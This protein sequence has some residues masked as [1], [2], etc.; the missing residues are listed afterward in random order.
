VSRVPL[1]LPFARWCLG[2]GTVEGEV[3]IR[4]L[5]TC[6]RRGDRVPHRRTGDRRNAD[7]VVRADVGRNGH[8]QR[9]QRVY[10]GRV[11][12]RVEHVLLFPVYDIEH[13]LL[14]GRA[15]RSHYML[16]I[17][18][19]RDPGKNGDDADHDHHLYQREALVSGR[20]EAAVD[21]P[22]A[23]GVGRAQSR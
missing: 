11:R 9:R 20:I 1:R 19:P 17:A 6:C 3:A 21:L 10:S 15:M 14:H 23:G 5:S 22:V 8:I 2:A 7:R 13:E 4:R 16:L 12:P 18:W